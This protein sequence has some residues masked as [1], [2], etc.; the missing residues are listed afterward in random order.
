MNKFSS[1]TLGK[2]TEEKAV[3][4]YKKQGYQVLNINRKGF[5]DLIVLKDREIQFFVEVKG[6]RHKIHSWQKQMHKKLEEMG[7]PS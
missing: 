4:Y 5:P 7:F 2:L 1:E 3:E 6:G